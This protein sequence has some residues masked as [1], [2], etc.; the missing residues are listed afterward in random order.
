MYE[1]ESLLNL[2]VVDLLCNSKCLWISRTLSANRTESIHRQLQEEGYHGICEKRDIAKNINTLMANLDCFIYTPTISV[3]QMMRRVQHVKSRTYLR[4]IQQMVDAGST[5]HGVEGRAAKDNPILES[6]K[7]KLEMIKDEHTQQVADAKY[8]TKD[9]FLKLH[10]AS[11]LTPADKHAVSKYLLMNAYDI[12]APEIV[13]PQWVKTYDNE[14]EKRVY[15]NLRDML[16][17][18]QRPE[19]FSQMHYGSI[20]EGILSQALH[21]LAESRYVK[22]RYAVD[23]M[24]PCR[25]AD[26]FA[27]NKVP[28]QELRDS[29]DTI[30]G[31]IVDEMGNMCMT[32]GKEKPRH[33]NW[34]FKNQLG[35]LNTALYDVLDMKIMVANKRRIAR[36]H[37]P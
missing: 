35:F 18:V 30:W 19:R 36:C 3:R 22:L 34:T 15:K 17:A 7:E 25:F 33:N 27:H 12:T 37:E 16:G 23:I 1:S 20:D 32:L 11:E 14:W 5:V 4:F 2:K 10:R 26:T 6:Q 29:I 28:A 21:K 24:M 31:D 9:D 8:L 13:A